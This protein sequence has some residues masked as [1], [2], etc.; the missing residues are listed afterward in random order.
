MIKNEQNDYLVRISSIVR[1]NG[2]LPISKSSFLKGVK[3]GLY[4]R[5]V[6][7]GPRI[8]CWKWS[9]INNLINNGI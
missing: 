1:P 4:P 9:E 6:K 7:L 3:D 2:V 8:T 5:P